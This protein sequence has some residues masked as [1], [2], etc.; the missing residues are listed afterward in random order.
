M[1]LLIR[2]YEAKDLDQIIAFTVPSF[3]P[4]FESFAKVLGPDIFP[5]IYPDWKKEQIDVATKSCQDPKMQTIVADIDG[6]VAGYLVYVLHEESKEGEIYLLAVDPTFQ[7]DGVGT[8]LNL[9]AIEIFKAA[10]MR[11]AVVG[12][13][14]DEGHAPARR[15]YEKAGFTRLPLVRYYQA[16]D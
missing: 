12:T 2:S 15:S 4:I 10:G 14:G 1:T 11:L 5:L 13:G 8:R 6:T 3:R 16:L 7:N 9:R